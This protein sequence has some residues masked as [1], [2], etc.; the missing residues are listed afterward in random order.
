MDDKYNDAMDWHGLYRKGWADMIVPESFSHPAK[1]ARGLI[2]KIY[3]H[4]VEEGWLAP[5]SVVVDPFGGVALGG[6]GAMRRGI[7]WVGV[8][9]E[10]KFVGLGIGFE[11][12]GKVTKESRKV[13]IRSNA[14][15]KGWFVVFG[16]DDEFYS[17]D[18]CYR[19]SPE[20][21]GFGTEEEA[22]KEL[23]A[24]SKD[25]LYENSPDKLSVKFLNIP[26]AG[27]QDSV[28]EFVNPAACG[29]T[30]EHEPHH[31]EGNI[32]YWNRRFG[33]AFGDKWGTAVLLQGDS[34]K[35]IEILQSNNT[36]VVISSP[37]FENVTSD[38]P[39]KSII[40][41]GLRMGASS[42]G[43]G[44][45]ESDGQLGRMSGGFDAVM[46]SPPY[47]EAR[48]GQ[49]SGQ[50]QCG[51]NDA[52]GTEDGQLG[53]MRDRGFDAA[54]SSPH[55]AGYVVRTLKDGLIDANGKVV[56]RDGFEIPTDDAYGQSVGQ[57]GA[58]KHG[59]LDAVISS[60]PY[61]DIAQQGG[62]KG[63]KE[64]GVGLTRG[65]RCFDEY[66]EGDGQLGRMDT[67]G[68]DAAISSPPF[69][70]QSADGGWQMLGKYAEEGRLTVKQVGGQSD[71]LYP[72]WDPS[73]DTAYGTS[74]GQLSEMDEGNLDAVA[75]NQ[76]DDG[77]DDN[78]WMAA[79]TIVEQTYSVLKKGGVAIWV[80]KAYVK[81]GKYIDFPDQWRRLCEAVGFKT[82]H[83]HR[84]WVVEERGTQYDLFGNAIT[85]KVERKS[86]FRRL[87]EAK[88]SPRIDWEEV[89]CMEKG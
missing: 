33:G 87:A 83:I 29:K 41:G 58:M 86:F 8:E 42:M 84:A 14:G 38:H 85:S 47:A 63:M 66:G 79:K 43:D 30:F 56:S 59:D 34:R 52:Y 32:E 2:D 75:S 74:E 16:N 21:D 76:G 20:G 44:Y 55:Y 23:V 78:F 15:A 39:S 13:V 72:S 64:R 53:G 65:E 36:D 5:G 27:E 49:E 11:C 88:G 61:G 67:G 7:N 19:N 40:D 18:S 25:P 69:R 54:I 9:L 73:R 57:L 50:E 28:Q 46:S 22:Q 37:P 12:D 10:K 4:A 6:L 81:G 45:G 82:M 17:E 51:H 35:L 48:I 62:D 1:F 68:L 31:V 89:I 3:E 24:L 77:S 26:V 70:G 71:K 80:V 60:P